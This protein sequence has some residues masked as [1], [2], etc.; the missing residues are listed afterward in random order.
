MK[1]D[2][3]RLGQVLGAPE[4]EGDDR[5]TAAEQARERK[6]AVEQAENVVKL[7]GKGADRRDR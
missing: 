6:I 7:A 1:T 5:E 3:G 4:R 2:L